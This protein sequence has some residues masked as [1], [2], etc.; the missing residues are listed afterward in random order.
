MI[1]CKRCQ[2]AFIVKNGLVR[3][4]PRYKCKAC[5]LNFIEGDM[6]VKENLVVK[7]ALAVILYSL[8]KASFGMLGKIF[9]S[10]L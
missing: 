5:G 3:Y 10:F 7:K 2:S 6:R 4:K 9:G 8:G 1:Q